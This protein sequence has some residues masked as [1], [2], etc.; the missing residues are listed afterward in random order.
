MKW[1]EPLK[2][3]IESHY[4]PITFKYRTYP[5]QKVW[6]RSKLRLTSSTRFVQSSFLQCSYEYGCHE[7]IKR[8]G[9]EDAF[10]SSQNY[11]KKLVCKR[12]NVGQATEGMKLE[13]KI[14]SKAWSENVQKS[15]IITYTLTENRYQINKVHENA[16]YCSKASATFVCLSDVLHCCQKLVSTPPTLTC[17]S[18][19]NLSRDWR[20]NYDRSVSC[21]RVCYLPF[22]F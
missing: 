1:N 16:I 8:F 2:L 7:D 17:A 18:G 11:R 3:H 6:Y 14:W 9:E 15:S 10:Y 5:D 12:A 22:P 20:R 4:A 19:S 13:F 21:F